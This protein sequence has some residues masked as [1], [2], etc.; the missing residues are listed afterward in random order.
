MKRP[1]NHRVDSMR[2]TPKL[3]PRHKSHVWCGVLATGLAL[4]LFH[5]AACYSVRADEPEAPLR[6]G[7]AAGNI[8]PPLGVSLNG[9]MQDRKA[10]YVHDELYARCLVLD[11][12]ATRLAI[13]VCDSCMVP[14]E[15]FDEAKRLVNE[16]TGLPVEQMLMSA[17]HAHSAPASAGVFQSDADQAYR[18][19]LAVRI[20]DA[21]RR[22]IENL[23]PARIGWGVGRVPGQV[24][25]RRWHMK[26]GTIPAN[27]FGSDSDQVKMNPPAGSPDLI[28]PAGPTDPEVS[29]VAVQSLDGRPIAL[30]ANYSLHYVGGTGSGH[31]SADYFG[32]F[33][34]RI[35]QLLGA[36]R[37]DPP[38]VGILSN[39]TSGDINNINFREPPKRREPY[40]QM[41]A[42]ADDVA[43]EAYRVYQGIQYVGRVPLGVRKTELRLGVRRP[44]SAEVARAKAI[45]EK[46][47]GPELKSIAEV[48][49]RETVLLGDYPDH[50]DLIL[51]AMRIGDLAIAAI[52]CE[53]FVEIG[54]EIKQKGPL[55]RTFVV[56]FGN[57]SY[58]YL[59]TVR[60]HKLGGYETWMGTN[61]VE[62]EAA[63]KIVRS[64]LEMFDEVD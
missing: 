50:V 59:P 3:S 29:V 64:I 7:A 14:R 39:G 32:M 44:D 38:F 28:E 35:Q 34:D 9:G 61:N 42:V 22:A 46:A 19:F 33:A 30:L 54:L 51:Q 58:G 21:V 11:D 41:R 43:Q 31:V 25:N 27:P 18:S 56:S 55:P 2:R 24:F 23:E 60:H 26:P 17:T 6:A 16:N 48:Y 49:A 52:P 15:V 57:G 13:V 53:V 4:L 36:D 1:K 12:G 37:Q 45:L 20:A 62:I 10:S 47:E 63:P 40:E 5:F 8:T